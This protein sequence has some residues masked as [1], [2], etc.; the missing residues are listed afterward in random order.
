MSATETSSNDNQAKHVT[1]VAIIGAGIGGLAFAVAL[2][3][4]VPEGEIKVDVYEQTHEIKEIG[5]GIVF[6]PRTWAIFQRLGVSDALEKHL[7]KKPDNERTL[8]WTVRKGNEENSADT[9]EFYR[10]G[11]PTHF[12]RAVVQ[13]SLLESLPPSVEVHL[14]HR[15]TSY[16]ESD[17]KVIL[18]FE[19]Q[20]SQ[21]CDLL[22]AADGI[23]SHI[24]AELIE[25]RFP[26]ERESIYPVWDGTIMYRSLINA[27]RVREAFPD[28]LSLH[29]PV[30]YCVTYPI[31]QG[32]YINMAALVTDY[33]KE[34]T[35]FE[36]P[37]VQ[38]TTKEHILSIFDGWSAEHRELVKNIDSCSKWTVEYLNVLEKVAIGRVALLGDAAHAMTP[39]LGSGAGQA[40]EDAYTLARLVGKAIKENIQ[41]HR[42]TEAYTKIRRPLANTVLQ[43]SNEMGRLACFRAPGYEHFRSDDK[44][45]L[46]RWFERFLND[47]NEKFGWTEKHPVEGEVE[48][49]LNIL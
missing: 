13:K 31:M 34:G 10:D 39:N 33:T 7:H 32:R 2:T 40:V 21:A 19:G 20:D 46:N 24:R 23:R 15:L 17:D 45:A 6:W 47:F 3:K 4:L 11:A 30:L 16:D 18:N 38:E 44:E 22:V 37:T 41:I 27:E 1:R 43:Q 28:H 35:R 25:K 29:K 14:F 49:A 12:H 36:G 26:D 42:V 8:V 9:L 5:A 48:K